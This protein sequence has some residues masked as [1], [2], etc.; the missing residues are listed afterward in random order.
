MKKLILVKKKLP[1]KQEF[2]QKI[3]EIQKKPI[4]PKKKVA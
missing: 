4:K 1:T 2:I 3:K